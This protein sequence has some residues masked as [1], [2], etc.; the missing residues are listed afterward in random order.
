MSVALI[1]SHPW[2]RRDSQVQWNALVASVKAH[3]P[4]LKMISFYRWPQIGAF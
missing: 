3:S 4:D 2:L 1:P